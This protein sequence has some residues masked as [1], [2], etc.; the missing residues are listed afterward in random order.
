MGKTRMAGLQSG[1]GRMMIDSVVWAQ[2]INVT[3]TWHTAAYADRQPRRHSKCRPVALRRSSQKDFQLSYFV[4]S[5][6]LTCEWD[7]DVVGAPVKHP[8]LGLEAWWRHGVFGGTQAR[9]YRPELS[10]AGIFHS[11]G[12]PLHHALLQNGNG[13]SASFLLFLYENGLCT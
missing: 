13:V 11:H 4:I 10:G 8:Q 12:K 1:E 2:Y 5:S 3:Y 9:I 6:L 7:D